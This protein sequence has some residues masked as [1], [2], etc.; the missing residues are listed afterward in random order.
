MAV[1]HVRGLIDAEPSLAPRALITVYPLG[2]T[3]VKGL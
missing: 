1:K 3:I 2:C